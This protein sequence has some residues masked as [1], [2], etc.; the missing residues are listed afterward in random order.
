MKFEDLPRPVREIV[1]RTFQET[2]V[3]FK[4]L[5]SDFKDRRITA[6]RWRAWSQIRA[7]K[8]TGGGARYSYITIAKFF[9]KDHTSVIHGCKRLAERMAAE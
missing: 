5:S 3:S 8:A 7:V 9:G 2:G 1:T 4:E 6:A